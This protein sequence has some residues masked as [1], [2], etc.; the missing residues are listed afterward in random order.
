MPGSATDAP[1]VIACCGEMFEVAGLERLTFEV[2]RMLRRRGATVHV[3]VNSWHSE[4]IVGL[5]TSVGATWSTG[6]YLHEFGRGLLNPLKLVRYLWDVAM[7]SRGLVRDARRVRATHVLVPTFLTVI[8]NGPALLWLRA[9][10]VRV[11]LRVGNHPIPG[12]FYAWLWSRVVAPLVD[13]VVANSAFGR[14]RLAATGIPERKL[15]LVRNCVSTRDVPPGTDAGVVALVAARRT[16][17]VVGQVAHFKGTHLAVEAVL[18]L[19]AEGYDVQLVVVGLLPAWPEDFV[20]YVASMRAAAEAA[21][22]TDRVHFVGERQNVPALMRAAYV[23]AAPIVQEETFG[24]VALES[25]QAGL[26]P[27]VFPTGGLV[28]LVDDGRTGVICRASTAD[29][30]V[31][32]LRRFL[33]DP[34]ARDAASQACLAMHRDSAFPYSREA[35]ERGWLTEFGAAV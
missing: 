11:I 6:D 19:L 33:D 4:K 18:R 27:V 17:L 2:L 3:I 32:G 5:A 16:V 7:T 29:A 28:E 34:S 10:G 9:R 14:G 8:R 24:N 1:R 20:A 22:R 35:F 13:R 23:L 30:L 15:G 21:G 25:T 12:R 26:P 31:E